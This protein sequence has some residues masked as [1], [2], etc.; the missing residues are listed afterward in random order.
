MSIDEWNVFWTAFGAIGTTIGSL[1][2]AITVVIA[3]KQYKQPLNKIIKV[4]FS[5][6]VSSF[7][8]NPLEFYC[9]NIKNRGIRQVQIDSVNIKGYSKILLLNYAQFSYGEK[10]NFPVIIEPEE[11]KMILFEV[12]NFRKEISKAVAEGVIKKRN[13]LIIFATDSLGDQY[14]C[15]TNIKIND[16]IKNI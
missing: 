13:E 10:I 4:E 14:Y 8:G 2:T 1:I 16:I 7:L 11:N 15:K 6:A 3:V 9:I 12:D 5:S